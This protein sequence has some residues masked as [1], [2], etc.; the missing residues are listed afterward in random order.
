MKFYE[1][2]NTEIS[3]QEWCEKHPVRETKYSDMKDP[4]GRVGLYPDQYETFQ[5]FV[6]DIWMRYRPFGKKCF[7]EKYENFRNDRQNRGSL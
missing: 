5:K 4:N 6:D 1:C 2:K 3:Y 7:F